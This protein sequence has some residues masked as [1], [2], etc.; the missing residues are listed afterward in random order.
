MADMASTDDQGA[1]R[2]W[3]LLTGVTVAVI[4]ETTRD[5]VR[6]ARWIAEAARA[7]RSAAVALRLESQHERAR[8]VGLRQRRMRRKLRHLP[9]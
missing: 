1:K 4:A 2:N 9:P 8:A 5:L 6:E 3:A 7:T